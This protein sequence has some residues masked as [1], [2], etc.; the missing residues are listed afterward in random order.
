MTFLLIGQPMA[1]VWPRLS[2]VGG[3]EFDTIAVTASG[4]RVVRVN[5]SCRLVTS[6]V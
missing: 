3:H 1:C 5:S 2:Q 4:T 6:S